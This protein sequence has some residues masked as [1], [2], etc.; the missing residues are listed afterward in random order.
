MEIEIQRDLRHTCHAC[1]II[2]ND[3]LEAYLDYAALYSRKYWLI[4][5]EE[6]LRRMEN[7]ISI[8]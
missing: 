8:I 5:Q 4:L 3:M 6:F 2:P 1:R 7:E